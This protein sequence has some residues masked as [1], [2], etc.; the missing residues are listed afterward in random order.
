MTKQDI[1]QQFIRQLTAE[2]DTITSAARSS[3]ATATSEAHHAEGKYDTFS[4]ETSYL[5][6]G[7]ARR[8]EELRQALERLHLMPVKAL[9]AN[10]PVQFSAMVRLQAANGETRA[11]YFASAGGGERLHMDGEDIVI[12]TSQS[13][14]GHAVLGK[15][16]G[17]S[18]TIHLAG[19]NQTFTVISVE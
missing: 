6:R 5:A 14:L 16:R 18:V 19:N 15:T 4:L 11:L 10:A 1:H 9:E 13:P 7:Q 12:V 2:L 17:E 3:I 8:V